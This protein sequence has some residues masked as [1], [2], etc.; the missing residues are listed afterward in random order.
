MWRLKT[1][2]IVLMFLLSSCFPPLIDPT[3]PLDPVT[4]EPP[5]PIIG[6]HEINGDWVGALVSD[7][8][9]FVT[10]NLELVEEEGQVTGFAFFTGEPVE[11]VGDV[12]GFAMDYV[13][14]DITVTDEVE[15]LVFTL[16]GEV[17]DGYFTGDVEDILG[18]TGSFTFWRSQE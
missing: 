9:F 7:V 11:T 6:D 18:T 17:E 13:V 1:L 12:T 2:V 10:L 15:T 3:D 5:P 16:T 14:I 4:P 8:N